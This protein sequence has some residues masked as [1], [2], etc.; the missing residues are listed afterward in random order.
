M[1]RPTRGRFDLL[2]EARREAREGVPESP[3]AD[4][5]RDEAWRADA[6]ARSRHSRLDEL[7]R[8][9]ES[10]DEAAAE[11]FCGELARK[12]LG[13]L[14][15]A[16]LLLAA[17]ERRRAQALAAYAFTLFDFARQRG[18]EGER[19][20]QINRWQFTLEAALSGEPVGQP[21][22]VAMA[23]EHGR[24]PWPEDALDA[25][26]DTARQRVGEPIPE[27]A[28]AFARYR[29]RLAA[30]LFQAVSGADPPPELAALGEALLAARGLVRVGE[31]LR[32]RLSP[33]AAEELPPPWVAGHPPSEAEV[34]AAVRRRGDE[35]RSRLASPPELAALPAT[36]RRA[37]TFLRLGALE[38]L[39]RL[40]ARGDALLTAPPRLGLRDR[41]LLLARA[42]WWGR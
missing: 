11:V 36:R 30:A 25:L 20:A 31:E 27:T 3:S 16:L 19:L 39:A 26:A 7:S 28:K 8:P 5:P 1:S 40:D 37:L 6:L 21:V 32:Q 22:F 24:Q 9:A 34:L 17:S 29:R 38:L 23:R 10:F 2:G 42:R 33:L 12:A 15:P 14:S 4:R 41:L 13:D 18:V 35:L